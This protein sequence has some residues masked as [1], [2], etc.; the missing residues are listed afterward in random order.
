MYVFTEIVMVCVATQ[1]PTGELNQRLRAVGSPCFGVPPDCRFHRL[2][3][4]PMRRWLGQSD[5]YFSE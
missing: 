5:Q 1:V 3:R 4:H 2:G